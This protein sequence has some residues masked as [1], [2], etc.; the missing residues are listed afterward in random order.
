MAERVFDQE[1]KQL[2]EMV[3]GLIDKVS[4]AVKITTDLLH[5]QDLSLTESIASLEQES[6]RLETKLQQKASTLMALHQPVARD[7]RFLLASM[8]LAH[9]LERIADQCLNISQRL[10]EAGSFLPIQWPPEIEEMISRVEEMLHLAIEAYLQ[11]NE[12]LA[13]LAIGQDI[14][15]DDLKSAVTSQYL[16]RINQ[17]SIEPARAVVYILLSRHLEKIGDLARNI[18]EEAYYLIKG[19]FIKHLKLT[20]LYH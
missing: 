15:L 1:L 19:E 11:G 5:R 18:A 20:D 7:L 6:D 12:E 17:K 2:K 14:F 16:E 13:S 8:N 4:Q 9:E 10:G 3:S